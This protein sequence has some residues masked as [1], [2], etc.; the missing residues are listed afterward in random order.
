MAAASSSGTA[1]AYVEAGY[2]FGDSV[3]VEPILG[4]E[5]SRQRN[6]GH[7]E[8]GAGAFNLTEPERHIDSLKSSLGVRVL[9]TWRGAEMRTTLEARAAWAHEFRSPSAISARFAA[10]STETAFS[11]PTLEA[12]RNS[13][14][15][16]VGISVACAKAVS[17]YA[18]V[19]AELS[20]GQRV[21]A[22][23]VGMR[24]R[25]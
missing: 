6:D 20:S 1:S 13:A 21:H 15:V 8:N 10:D 17:F 19:A 7:T 2:A 22:F 5:W 12:P 25:W 9:R 14:I 23:G 11:V 18:D 3:I 16:G 4:L 24:Y